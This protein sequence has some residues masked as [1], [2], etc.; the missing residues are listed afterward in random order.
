MLASILAF[1]Q[2]HGVPV[3]IASFSFISLVLG[4]IAALLGQLGKVA[5]P[6]LASVSN[7]LQAVIHFLNGNVPAAAAAVKSDPASQK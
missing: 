1:L 4:G 2:L 7:A 6:W 3:V 5:P